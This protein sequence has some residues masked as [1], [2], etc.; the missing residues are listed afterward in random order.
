VLILAGS[1]ARSPKKLLLKITATGRLQ[2]KAPGP[3]KGLKRKSFFAA[4]GRKK[5][6]SGKPGFSRRFT[7]RKMRP[8]SCLLLFVY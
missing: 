8:N 6:W 7:P 5:D 4:L 2:R 1:M 3:R